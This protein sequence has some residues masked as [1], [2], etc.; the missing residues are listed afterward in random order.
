[1]RRRDFLKSAAA[2]PACAALVGE[3]GA[4]MSQEASKSTASDTASGPLG[5]RN[6]LTKRPSDGVPEFV[7]H[8]RETDNDGIGPDGKQIP[9]YRSTRT[10][11]AATKSAHDPAEPPHEM[12]LTQEEQDILD[13]KQGRS[14]GKGPPDH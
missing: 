14:Q 10:G 8:W 13:G 2:A 7:Q 3:T 11:S 1:M 4:A 6:L 5:A 12:E 9:G